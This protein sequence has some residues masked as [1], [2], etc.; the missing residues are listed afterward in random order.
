LLLRPAFRYSSS[1]RAY[2]LRVVGQ[3][4]GPVLRANRRTRRR[5]PIDGVDRRGRATTV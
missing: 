4:V 1:R 3:N 5:R 2:V